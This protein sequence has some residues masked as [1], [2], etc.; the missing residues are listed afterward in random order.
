MVK[1]TGNLLLKL[2][3]QLIHISGPIMQEEALAIAKQLNVAD[4]KTS[5]GWLSLCN[6]HT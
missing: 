5:T 1:A 4:F 2:G 3:G 6:V